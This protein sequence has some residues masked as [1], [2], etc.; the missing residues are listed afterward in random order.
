M[1]KLSLQDDQ[2]AE[3]LRKSFQRDLGSEK[4][5]RFC[6]GKEMEVEKWQISKFEAPRFEALNAKVL[7]RSSYVFS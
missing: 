3:S 1:A 7:S 5:K 6:E 4:T 2:L